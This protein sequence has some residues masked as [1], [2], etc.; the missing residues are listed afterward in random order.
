MLLSDTLVQQFTPEEIEGVLAHELGHQRYR[1]ITKLLVISAVGSWIAFTLTRFAAAHWVA[2]LGLDGLSDIGGFP[3][4][5]LWFSAL[6]L[7]S[8]PLQNGLS[9]MF[10]WEADRFATK[11]TTVPSARKRLPP[12]ARGVRTRP[13]RAKGGRAAAASEDAGKDAPGRL[14]C[15]SQPT[16]SGPAST[17]G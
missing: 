12:P 11:T 9:R 13:R 8:L 5:M 14:Q 3:I 16:W 17:P 7:L 6:G 10:E 4:L 2:W 15:G 1:H